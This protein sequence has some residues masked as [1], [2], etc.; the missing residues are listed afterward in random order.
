ML[1]SKNDYK[2]SMA[3]LPTPSDTALQYSQRL[4]D[5][6]R[7]EIKAAGGYISFARFMEL[8]LYA[9]GLGYYSA[10]SHKLGK[11]GDFITAPEISPL[12]AKCIAKQCQQVFTTLKNSSILEIGAGS[13]K[14]A[15]ELLL[16][17]ERLQALPQKYFILEVSADLRDKQQ[18]LLKDTCPHLFSRLCWLDHLPS[19]KMTGIILANEVMD[20]LP[21]HVFQIENAVIKERCVAI[22]NNKFI[23]KNTTPTTDEI[24]KQVDAL[25][26]LENGYT[27][28]INLMLT[29]WIHSMADALDEGVILLFDYGY[30]R[31]EYYHPDRDA[32]T[33]M[34]YYQHQRHANPLELVGLQDITAHVDFTRVAESALDAGLLLAGYTT[35][36]AFLLA[37][38]ITEFVVDD[39][40][41]VAQY[42]QS[43]AIKL[44][45]LP[46]EMGE[47][48]KVM[49]LSKNYKLP[50][51]GFALY[52]R[53]KDL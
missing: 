52:D 42:Q 37:C 22:E 39:A 34:C 9:P 29:P 25:P 1:F 3:T 43:Q 30:G 24:T 38:G 48:I 15:S 18:V 11:H 35:Q 23:W 36:A 40:D 28:E 6:I 51:M 33:L 20:A 44:L 45:T 7:Q 13:G 4:I 53:R 12:F 26:L 16:E 49:A 14:L 41:A 8:T 5:Q 10:G 17:L 31:Q 19:Q 21:S 47:A 46:S 32:G 2:L 27:S 50:L